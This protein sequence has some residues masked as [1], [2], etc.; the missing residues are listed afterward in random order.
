MTIKSR[1]EKLIKKFNNIDVRTLTDAQLE[2]I[3][4]AGKASKENPYSDI[5][6]EALTD[7]QLDRIIDGEDPREV[8]GFDAL[9]RRI[10]KAPDLNINA[11]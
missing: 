1:L 2:R 3:V 6:L 10:P 8:V 5:D 11:E 7:E 9:G 4:A